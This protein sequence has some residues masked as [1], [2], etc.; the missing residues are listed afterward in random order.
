LPSH[1]TRKE[2][3]MKYRALLILPVVTVLLAGCSA[4]SGVASD[5]SAPPVSSS[6]AAPTSAAPVAKQNPTIGHSYKY[7]DGLV[8]SVSDAGKFEP[9]SSAAKEPADHYEAYK[10]TVKNGTNATFDPT[11][12][13]VDAQDGDTA[14]QEVTDI[15]KNVGL[16]PQV[17]LLPGKS[18]SWEAV[19]GLSKTPDV[20]IQVTPDFDHDAAIFTK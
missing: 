7:D 15:E 14:A 17:K 11:I 20:T 3:H 13:Q 9:S 4:T 8:V 16:P 6:A 19:F 5:D 12:V 2:I 18:V 1:Q 10:V